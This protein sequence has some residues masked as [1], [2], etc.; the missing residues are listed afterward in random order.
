MMKVTVSFFSFSALAGVS[1]STL[2]LQGEA[3]VAELVGVLKEQFAG[4]FP[5]AERAIYLVNG[6]T[7][8]RETPLKDGDRVLML[9]ILGGG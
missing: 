2:D 6:Q 7:G 8:T 1:G 3:T 4:M 5:Q 9:Q